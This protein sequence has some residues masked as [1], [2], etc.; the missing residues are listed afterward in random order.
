LLSVFTHV[1]PQFVSVAGHLQTPAEQMNP[2]EHALHAAPQ[3]CAS[4]FVLN[5]HAVPV[6]LQSL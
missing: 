5:W 2:G 1:P 6:P 4:E 3:C